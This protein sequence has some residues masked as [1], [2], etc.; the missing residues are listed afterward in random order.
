MAGEI[1]PY[2]CRVTVNGYVVWFNVRKSM[3]PKPVPSY[4]SAEAVEDV[5]KRPLW[6][7]ADRHA[8]VVAISIFYRLEVVDLLT[9]KRE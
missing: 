6:A 8:C 1:A 4:W 7:P 3:L 9:L 2:R 5:L